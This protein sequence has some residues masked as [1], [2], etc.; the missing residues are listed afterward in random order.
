MKEPA[1]TTKRNV[2]LDRTDRRTRDKMQPCNTAAHMFIITLIRENQFHRI[3]FNPFV[4]TP[5]FKAARR[6]LQ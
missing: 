1:S 2:F 6:R 4:T 3:T 5:E